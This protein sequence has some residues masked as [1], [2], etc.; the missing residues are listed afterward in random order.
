MSPR[1]L[2]QHPHLISLIPLHALQ[3]KQQA[4]NVPVSH[5]QDESEKQ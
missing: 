4:D 2:G 3:Q 5:R 1:M